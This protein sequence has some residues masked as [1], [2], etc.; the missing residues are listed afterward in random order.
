MS[1]ANPFKLRTI[2]LTVLMAGWTVSVAL[3][4][5]GAEETVAPLKI[6][7][8]AP[9]S[10]PVTAFGAAILDG[11]LYVYGGHLG[12]THKYSSD[13]QANKLLRLNLAKPGQWETVGEGPRRTGLAMV[14]HKGTL[15]RI[16]GWEARNA[17]GEKQQL[18]S[19]RDFARFD[20]KSGAW[21]ELTPLPRGRSSHDAAM[22]GDMLYVVGGWELKG[23]GDGEWHDTALVCDLSQA[24]PQWKEIAKPPFVIR[25]LAVAATGGK[26]YAVGGMDDGNDTTTAMHVYDPNSNQWSK[27]PAMPGQNMDGF[28]MSAFGTSRGLFASCRTGEVQ[29]FDPAINGWISLGKLNHPRMSHRL[30]AIDDQHLV[31]VGGVSRGGKVTAVESLELKLTANQR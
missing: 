24:Q 26:I 29:Q 21:Q 16:G 9:L 20:F 13:Q 6:T 1:F 22:L 27:A 14:A 7:E 11:S 30:L 17:A 28:G 12:T 15:Y 19:S 5:S 10:A 25:A 18:F 2:A 23:D 8:L 31:V 4:G 3:V